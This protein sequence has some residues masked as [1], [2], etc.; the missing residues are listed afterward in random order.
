LT[1]GSIRDRIGRKPVL[2]AGIAST[3]V[4]VVALGYVGSMWGIAVII[5]A[6]GATTGTI[7]I[8]SPV[9]ASEA[10][11]P[12][13]RGAAI[14]AYRTFFDLGSI[15]GPPIMTYVLT[16]YGPIYCFYLASATLLV[17]L[18]PSLTL[19]ETKPAEKTLTAH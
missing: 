11:D 4:L 7:W 18:I 2:L 1:M 10:V 17:S 13:H 3:A 15:F 16:A 8:I 19:K 5:F 12:Q 6:L 14:G 9:L